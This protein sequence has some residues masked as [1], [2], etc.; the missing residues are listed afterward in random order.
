MKQQVLDHWFKKIVR[1]KI[2]MEKA[3]GFYLG[4]P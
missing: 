3:R 2:N 1:G 4:N